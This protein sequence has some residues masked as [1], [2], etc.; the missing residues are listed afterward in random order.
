MVG[1]II[2]AAGTSRRFGDDKRKALLANGKMVIEQTIDNVLQHFDTIILTLRHDDNQFQQTLRAKYRDQALETFLAPNSALGM[3]H[4]LANTIKEAGNWD[5]VFVF[6]ADMPNI[7]GSAI[8]SLTTAL[9][10]DNIVIPLHEGR[11]GHP[12]GFGRQF[13]DQLS[14]LEGDAGAKAVLLNSADKVL[15]VYVDDP[16][17]LQDIDQ[18][19]DLERKPS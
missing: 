5:G 13:F 6:L 18:P 3:G 8:L 7:C 17:V 15:E 19:E 12:V 2:L 1:A 10:D 4:S 11:R 9:Q 14:A 16:G